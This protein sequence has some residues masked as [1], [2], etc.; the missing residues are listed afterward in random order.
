MTLS[1]GKEG[2]KLPLSACCGAEIKW[3]VDLLS[4]ICPKCGI[5]NPFHKW[6]EHDLELIREGRAMSDF[7]TRRGE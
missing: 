6:S 1:V 5:K 4:N 2:V 7:D 3:S